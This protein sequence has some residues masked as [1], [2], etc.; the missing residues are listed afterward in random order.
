VK[1]LEAYKA[2]AMEKLNLGSR[3]VMVR[4]ATAQGWLS[5]P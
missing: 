4:Y 1:T 3:V 5:Q 2:W